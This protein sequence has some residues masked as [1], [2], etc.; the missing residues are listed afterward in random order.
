MD[1][2]ENTEGTMTSGGNK[3]YN[4]RGLRHDGWREK[5]KYNM[6]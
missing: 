4:R 1:N 2:E 5:R 3:I 6:Q